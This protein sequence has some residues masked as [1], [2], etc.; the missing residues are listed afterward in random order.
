MTEE[1]QKILL[2]K[3]FLSTDS[4]CDVGYTI[5]YH[6]TSPDGLLGIL[7]PGKSVK[8]WFTRYDSL[9]DVNER[10]DI[11]EY[12][13]GY[14]EYQLKNKKLSQEFYEA[15]MKIELSD[16]E[17]LTYPDK[18]PVTLE[19]SG[20]VNSWT[21]IKSVPCDT[22]LCC[23]SEEADLLPMWNYY[24]KSQ[25]YE[26]YSIGFSS[27]RLESDRGF[28]KGYSLKLKRVLYTN[29]EKAD[30]FNKTLLPF[31]DQ[32]IK[33]DNVERANILTAIRGQLNE[34][35]FVFKNSCFQHEK[36]IRAILRVP[37]DGALPDCTQFEI[38]YRNSN[39]YIVPYIEY[40]IQKEA[41]HEITVAPL[42]Q[43]DIS[44]NNLSEMLKQRGYH[45][46]RIKSSTVPIRF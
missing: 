22:Y 25:H 36:E 39:G 4:M 34:F 8:L 46:I 40:E 2:S 20:E 37:R 5:V 42:L 10:K 12:L 27:D 32:Y 30:F 45:D 17:F 3:E 9:N 44:K 6:Y 18:Y 16:D 7:Q 11:L 43:A 26:G 14:C 35:Q 19:A 28:E 24:T 23:F 21:A 13:H 29:F 41:V 38:R 31:D 15:I 33:G 1:L